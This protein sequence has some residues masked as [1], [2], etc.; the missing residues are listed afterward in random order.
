MFT[1]VAQGAPH[2]GH[3]SFIQLSWLNGAAVVKTAFCVEI[4]VVRLFRGIEHSKVEVLSAEP[5][6]GPEPAAVRRHAKESRFVVKLC[7]T[8]VLTIN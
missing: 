8:L 2:V 5:D 4:C 6:R 3:W 7:A 1:V